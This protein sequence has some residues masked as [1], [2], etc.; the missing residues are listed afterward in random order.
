MAKKH[1]PMAIAYDFDGT[2]AP[3]NMQER[4]FLPD[5]GVKPSEFWA[6]VTA[7]TKEHQADYVLVYMEQMLRKADAAGV[8]VKKEDFE[9]QGESIRLFEGVEG[10]FDRI[11]EYGRGKGV[12]I[13]HY[14]VSSGNAE[15][16]S[17][18]PI[19]AKFAQVYASNVRSV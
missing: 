10:W 15:I 18:T 2:L 13:E 16:V 19:A 7:L 12:Q 8:L 1:I 3:G 11:T 5:I 14:L 9:K 6:E 4:Q 17:G